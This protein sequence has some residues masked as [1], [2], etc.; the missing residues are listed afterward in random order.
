[1]LVDPIKSN[2]SL[3]NHEFV[4]SFAK[5]VGPEKEIYIAFPISL[6]MLLERVG[7]GTG[8]VLVNTKVVIVA[9][10]K[11]SFLLVDAKLG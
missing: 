1:M 5:L 3:H 4:D 9:A 8:W 6:K 11:Y 10:L 7:G 2:S